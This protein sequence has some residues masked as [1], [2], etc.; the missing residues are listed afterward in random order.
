M[1]FSGHN[2]HSCYKWKSY[3]CDKLFSNQFTYILASGSSQS[4]GG[5]KPSSSSE[6]SR[7]TRVLRKIEFCRVKR[8]YNIFWKQTKKKSVSIWHLQGTGLSKHQAWGPRKWSPRVSISYLMIWSNALTPHNV[9]PCPCVFFD[10]PVRDRR[11]RMR[12]KVRGRIDDERIFSSFSISPKSCGEGSSFRLKLS[13][14]HK[15]F[16][17][18]WHILCSLHEASGGSGFFLTIGGRSLQ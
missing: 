4:F 7:L 6:I 12:Q 5:L 14:I 17:S 1:H 9:I 11:M 16:H 15:L 2:Y 8:K 18:A 13:S 3:R 10:D